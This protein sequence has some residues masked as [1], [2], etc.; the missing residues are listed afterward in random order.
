M[1]AQCESAQEAATMARGGLAAG[2]SGRWRSSGEVRGSYPHSG[3]DGS[4]SSTA[5]ATGGP[6]SAVIA[7]HGGLLQQQQSAT[8]DSTAAARETTTAAARP[9]RR[10]GG[11]AEEVRQAAN[12]CNSP[13]NPGSGLK[14]VPTAEAPHRCTAHA[15]LCNRP[16]RPCLS[17]PLQLDGV[18]PAACAG[19]AG[20]SHGIAQRTLRA[21]R[22]PC[23]TASHR[24]ETPTRPLPP[25]I[26]QPQCPARFTR[27][28]PPR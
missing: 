13:G 28:T 27:A 24:P 12:G 7:A 4:K 26:R 9:T 17:K 2:A 20:V 6:R 16:D 1:A 11:G 8:T 25:N 5:C 14:R 15:P 21:P 22:P 3:I 10:L 19:S 18:L 23:F